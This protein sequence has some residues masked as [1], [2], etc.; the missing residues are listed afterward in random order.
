MR[1]QLLVVLV[2]SGVCGCGPRNNSAPEPSTPRGVALAPD[3]D[4]GKAFQSVT[5]IEPPV[6]PPQRPADLP[7]LSERGGKQIASAKRLIDEQ[8]YTEASLELERA[9]RFDPNHFEIHRALALLHWQAGNIERA[10]THATKTIE[11][12]PDC[13]AAHYILGRCQAIAGDKSAALMSFRTA[14][15]CSDLN[16]DK[17]TA[18]LCHYHLAQALLAEGYLEAALTEFSAFERSA[19]QVGSSATRLELAALLRSTHGSAGEERSQVLEKLGRFGEAADALAPLMAGDPPDVE[20]SKRYAQLLAKAGRFEDALAAAQVVPVDDADFVAFLFDLHQRA[21][22]PERIVDDLR[23]RVASKPDDPSLV[24]H[25]ADAL[26]RVKRIDEARAELAGFLARQPDAHAVRLR[27]LDILLALGDVQEAIRQAGEGMRRSP[28]RAAEWE[29]R[30]AAIPQGTPLVET[31]LSVPP[32]DVDDPAVAYLRGVVARAAQRNELADE[33]FARSL[34]IQGDFIS[35]RVA[36]AESYLDRNRYED[37][38]RVAGRREPDRPED[39][40]LEGVLGRVYDRLD[41]GEK[42]ELHFRAATQLDRGDLESMFALAQLYRRTDRGLQAQR[43]LRVLLEKDPDHESARE[44][45]ALLYLRD[46]KVDVAVREIE[47][48]KRRSQSPT[49]VARCRTLLEPE[50]RRDAAARRQVLME[51][52]KEGRPDAATWI[53]LAETYEEDEAAAMRDGYLKALEV[54]PRSEEAA[55]GVIRATQALLNYEEAAQRLKALIQVRPNR[56]EWRLALIELYAIVQDYP[57]VLALTGEAEKRTDLPPTR[58][59]AYRLAML[60]ALMESHQAEEAIAQLTAWAQA[61]PENREWKL[62]LAGILADEKRAAEAVPI[63]EGLLTVEGR[64]QPPRRE[65]IEAL[66]EAGHHD[67]ALQYVLDWLT[68]DPQNDQF[69]IFLASVLAHNKQFDDAFEI[70]Q[71]RLLRTPNREWWQDFVISRLAFAKRYEEAL[72]WVE[73][74]IEEVT[75]IL[76]ALPEGGRRRPTDRLSPDR[77]IY[78]PNEPATPESLQERLF[79]LRLGQ[80]GGVPGLTSALIL[81]KRHREAEQQVATWLESEKDAQARAGYLFAL[82]DCQRAQNNEGAAAGSLERALSLMPKHATLNNDVAYGW[83]DRGERLDEA[84]KLIRYAVGQDAFTARQAAYL[85]TYGWLLYKR[86]DCEGALKW[87]LRANHAREGKDPVIHDHLGDTYWRL[88][89]REKALEHWQLVVERSGEREEAA[90]ISDDE[91]RAGIV[92]PKKLEDAKAG[93]KPAI[94]PLGGEPH[95]PIPPRSPAPEPAGSED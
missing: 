80:R 95:P 25:L 13:A 87:L 84:E 71:A 69:L 64:E 76:R 20:R 27:L 11:A 23:E 37:A 44:L 88:G 82:A 63:F 66:M 4:A 86:G 36:L 12:N 54:D 79:N 49:T 55:L 53:A 15:L 28:E 60:E 31:L 26:E 21:G 17:E 47:E 77:L 40:R 70:A 61:E 93:R 83:I 78:R 46:N 9:L 68:D 33:Y 73:N 81:N 72:D 19:A 89:N 51:A 30:I 7:P 65:L 48:L 74:L 2:L 18:T 35:A 3:V 50:L 29:A 56:H 10:R 22:H 39:A 5:R 24:M 94:A 52:M 85:D 16:E 75:S 91:H 62:R 59:R 43:Q 14:V 90:R 92:A 67:R 8:R 38:L 1:Y 42:A 6:A 34:E 32:K 45:L 58:R 41:D 57:K